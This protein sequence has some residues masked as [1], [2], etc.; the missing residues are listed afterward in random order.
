MKLPAPLVHHLV[1]QRRSPQGERGL[2]QKSLVAAGY[3]VRSLPARGAWVETQEED[4]HGVQVRGR[5]PQGERGLKHAIAHDA[6]RLGG[7][8]PQGERG[9]K[10]YESEAPP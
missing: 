2:K 1:K 5:S 3:A 9:L 4:L 6:E 8:S 7:R 10:Q